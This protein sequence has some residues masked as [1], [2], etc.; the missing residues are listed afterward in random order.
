VVK[1]VHKNAKHVIPLWYDRRMIEYQHA[2]EA[3][4]KVPSSLV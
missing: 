3:K 1:K 4:E 2:N